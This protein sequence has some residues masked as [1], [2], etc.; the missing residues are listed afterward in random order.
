MRPLP[1][2]LASPPAPAA[3]HCVASAPVHP[4]L[5]SALH[6][7]FLPPRR[8]RSG[9][10]SAA[11]ARNAVPDDVAGP[12]AGIRPTLAVATSDMSAGGEGPGRTHDLASR[13][14]TAAMV[15]VVVAP[16]QH[17]YQHRCCEFLAYGSTTTSLHARSWAHCQPPS[18][19][20]SPESTATPLNGRSWPLPVAAIV[21]DPLQRLQMPVPGRSI[22]RPS[23][24]VAAIVADPL[25]RL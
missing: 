19:R 25:Q 22:G 11:H 1:S 10:S 7:F 13:L 24:P 3:P 20:H 18:R 6:I 15:R 21:A 9:G 23:C 14:G 17:R 12:G 2:P 16:Y 5:A 8:A 4:P